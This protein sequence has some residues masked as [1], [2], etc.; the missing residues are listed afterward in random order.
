M[1]EGRESSQAPKPFSPEDFVAAK[2]QSP[3]PPLTYWLKR[4]L[5]CNPFYLVSAALLLYGV[6]RVS[7]DPNFLNRETAQLAFNFTSLQ[8]YEVLL[9]L[10]ATF[11]ARQ[12]IWY[13]STLL[14]VLENGLLLVPFILISQAAKIG[15]GFIW[16]MCLAGGLPW[17]KLAEYLLFLVR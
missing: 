8:F 12:R 15:N 1:N 5:A 14:V 2:P 11:L 4:F 9:V 13:D 17:D 3:G 10:T 7:V 16:A 6:Y